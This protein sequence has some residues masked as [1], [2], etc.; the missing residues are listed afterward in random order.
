MRMIVSRTPFRIS[1][2]GGGTDYP[3]WYRH[4]GGAVIGTTINKYC[5]LSLRRLPPFFEHRHRIVYSKVECVERLDEIEH[6]SVRAVF[7]S[8]GVDQGLELHHDGDLPARSGLGSS[9]SFTIGLINALRALDGK[10]SSPGFLARE[11]IRI[12]QDVIGEAVGSQDQIWAAF[13]GTN[14]ITINPDDSFVVQPM[15]MS[16][17]RRELFQSH[18]MLFFTGVSRIASVI[19]GEKIANLRNRSTELRAMRAMVDEAADI[20]ADPARP[21]AEFGKLLHENWTIKRSLADNV[22]TPLIDEI[23]QAARDAGALG[24]KVLGAGG[25]GFLLLFAEPER[26]ALIR[27]RLKD[28]ISVGF[29]VGSPGSKIVVYEPSG[30]ENS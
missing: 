21:L 18:L 23:Y 1:F 8:H 14:M 6:P 4:H 25:G 16:K 29:T 3:A 2:F 22:A 7:S 5:Y 19:A 20:L 10:I 28:L 27:E 30:L 11:A 12:E 24:G 13:G 17:E 15:I 26:Q 9:S